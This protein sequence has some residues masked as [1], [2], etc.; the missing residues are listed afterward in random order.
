MNIAI[1]AI[2]VGDRHRKDFGD[3]AL[4][5][6]SIKR[7][8]LIH[9][10]C[11]D[12]NRRL[13]AGERRI[14]AFENLGRSHIPATVLPISEILQGEHDE[15]ELRK[16]FTVSERVE[17]GKALEQVLEER[18]GSNQHSRKGKEVENFPPPTGKT[19]DLAA[20]QAGFG[21]GKTYQQAK[22]VVEHADPALVTAMDQGQVAVSTAAEAADL[23]VEDQQTI[24]A[25]PKNEQRK[26]VADKKQMSG[27]FTETGNDEWYT[28]SY[29]IDAARAAMGGIDT[30]PASCEQAQRTVKADVW[31]SAADDGLSKTWGGRV[32]LNPPYSRSLLPKFADKLVGSIISGDVDSA[33]VLVNSGTETGWF[34]SI[35]SVCDVICLL[36]SRVNFIGPD[37]KGGDGNS[38]PQTVFYFGDDAQK[39]AEA[40]GELGLVYSKVTT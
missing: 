33:V 36:S 7:L 23:P 25:M 3:I 6:E 35:A 14:K 4:L 27:A 13:V 39:F 8:G 17:I 21:N 18:I 2:K 31:Y 32:W 10:I 9:P 22:K 34:H 19:R 28:P 11:V 20:K 26:A 12:T 30:D 38:R 1:G 15:N 40:F 29:I 37:G 24:A 16:D 5:A